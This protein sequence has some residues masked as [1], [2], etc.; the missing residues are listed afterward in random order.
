MGV[1]KGDCSGKNGYVT[2]YKKKASFRGHFDD[3]TVT[4]NGGGGD[5]GGKWQKFA[6]MNRELAGGLAVYRKKE[7]PLDGNIHIFQDKIF[8]ACHYFPTVSLRHKKGA[9]K[10]LVGILC[11]IRGDI[12]I[13]YQLV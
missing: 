1:T 2:R 6:I 3:V 8:Q 4:K 9:G 5:D 13:H 11:K 7:N 10:K 12:C